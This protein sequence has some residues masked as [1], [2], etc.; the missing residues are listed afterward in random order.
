MLSYSILEG[1]PGKA[2]ESGGAVRSAYYA[3][4]ILEGA[5]DVATLQLP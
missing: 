4:R 3:S 5:D 1:L 2:E